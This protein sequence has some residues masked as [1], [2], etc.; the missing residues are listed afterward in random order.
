MHKHTFCHPTQTYFFAASLFPKDLYV[1]YSYKYIIY[2]TLNPA[3][4]LQQSLQPSCTNLGMDGY[5]D[6]LVMY[7][8]VPQSSSVRFFEA[9]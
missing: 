1:L 9:Y 7:Y 6:N 2:H 5:L 3:R 4:H 8:A